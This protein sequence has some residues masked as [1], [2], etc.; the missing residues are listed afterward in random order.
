M[1][2]FPLLLAT[3]VMLGCGAS[4]PKSDPPKFVAVVGQFPSITQLTPASTPANSVPFMLTV[5]GSNFGADAV[6][7]L[8]G[9][10]QH[11][12]FITASQLVVT[13]TP[14][15]LQFTGLA[16]LYVRTLGQ[17]SN[18]VDFDVTPQ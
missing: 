18:T 5:N 17:N 10:P 8:N 14:A 2:R 9:V 15:D 1:R 12:I 7:F 11:T 3:L 6:A 4:A 16:P 13:M